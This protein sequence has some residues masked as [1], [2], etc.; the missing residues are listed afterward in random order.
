ML[1]KQ[2][3]TFSSSF[4]AKMSLLSDF[5]THLTVVVVVYFYY[6]IISAY[7]QRRNFLFQLHVCVIKMMPQKISNLHTLCILNILFTKRFLIPE[8]KRKKKIYMKGSNLVLSHFYI[9]HMFPKKCSSHRTLLA[10]QFN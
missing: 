2:V 9:P 10:K 5:L 7:I 3:Y 4:L 6:I 1:V 8:A